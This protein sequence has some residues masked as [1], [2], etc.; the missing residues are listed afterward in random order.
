MPVVRDP[1][2]VLKPIRRF[3]RDEGHSPGK[4]YAWLAEGEVESLV[5]GSRRFIVLASYFDFIDRQI[6]ASKAREPHPIIA[7]TAHRRRPKPAELQQLQARDRVAS[8]NSP[9]LDAAE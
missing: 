8:R 7:R 2:H 3:C 6:A 5:I 9:P 4:V 1:T